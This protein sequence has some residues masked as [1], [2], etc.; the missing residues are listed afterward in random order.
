[1]N[2]DALLLA[3]VINGTIIGSVNAVETIR[4]VATAR[5]T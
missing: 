4:E 3:L 2:D 1:M 5:Y